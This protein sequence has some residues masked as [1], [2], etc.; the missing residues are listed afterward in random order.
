MGGWG[1]GRRG[2]LGVE[3][4]PPPVRPAWPG[5]DTVCDYSGASVWAGALPAAAL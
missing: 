3:D 2:S 4:M 5:R 1:P